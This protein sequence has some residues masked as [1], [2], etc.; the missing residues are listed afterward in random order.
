MK[1]V[2]IDKISILSNSTIKQAMQAINNGEMGVVFV[3]DKKGS[4]NN[5]LTDGDIRRTLLKG[6][7]LESPVTEIDTSE[8]TV[9]KNNTPLSELSN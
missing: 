6:Y 9:I 7:G 4:L 2:D 1:K 5:L 8:P 3:V